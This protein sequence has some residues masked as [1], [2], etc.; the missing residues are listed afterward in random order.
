M[1]KK[2]FCLHQ[3]KVHA[4]VDL[5]QPMSVDNLNWCT[6]RQ[7]LICPNCGEVKILNY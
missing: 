1:W 5:P 3:W 7:V 6:K 2:L 4:E